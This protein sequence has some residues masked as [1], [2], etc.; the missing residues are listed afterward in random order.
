V[1]GSSF[2]AR[3]DDVR[4]EQAVLRGGAIESHQIDTLTTANIRR[5]SEGRQ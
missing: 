3:L 4:E 2:K 5:P 1:S